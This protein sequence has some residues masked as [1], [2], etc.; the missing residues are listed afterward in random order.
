[1]V[2]FNI[3]DLSAGPPNAMDKEN[4]RM[5]YFLARA[6][7]VTYNCIIRPKIPAVRDDPMKLHIL[8]FDNTFH[9]HGWTSPYHLIRYGGY[10]DEYYRNPRY[11]LRHVID[12]VADMGDSLHPIDKDEIIFLGE[13]GAIGGMVRLEKIRNEL[14]ITGAHGWREN[15]HLDWYDSYDRFLDRSGMRSSFP[16]VDDLTMAIGANMHYFHGRIIENCRIGNKVDAY[17]LNGWASAGT[18]TDVVDTY[19]N[20]TGDPSIIRHY[21][22]PCYVAAK[23]RDKVLPAGGRTVAD[24]YI[25]NEENLRGRHTLALTLTDPDGSI[26]FRE[27]RDVRVLGGEDFGQLLAEGIALPPVEQAGYHRLEGKLLDRKNAT[28]AEGFDD[29]F[30]ADYMNGPGIVGSVA[31]ID[32]SGTINAFL[33]NARGVTLPDFNPHGPDIDCLVIGAHDFDNT[34]R[35]GLPKNVRPWDPILERVLNGMTL[36]VLDQPDKWAE[37]MTGFDYTSVKYA[38]EA[39]WGNRG[40]FFTGHSE[41]L[42]GLPAD[43]GMNWEYQVFYHNDVWGLRFDPGGL[44]TVVGLAG[45]HSDEILQAMCRVRFG[46]GEIIITTLPI[47]SA[48]ASDAPQS[49]VAKK[50]FMNLLETRR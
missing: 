41:L 28:V 32:T 45:V 22:Q 16:T 34:R 1:M 14:M 31:V 33:K 39:H 9:Y 30:I 40:R 20:P 10:L 50:M 12:P 26:V 18:R 23:L 7:I 43:Q 15:E 48:L 13:E 46:E 19:R 24:I 4:I 27:N 35:L 5:V 29:I 3:D 38:G 47:L 42:D 2:I 25:V 49:A 6:R 8:P 37:R 11:Y 44:E 36:I 17:V 21:M